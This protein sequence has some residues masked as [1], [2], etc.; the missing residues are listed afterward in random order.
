VTK[1]YS[2]VTGS[3]GRRKIV[4]GTVAVKGVAQ[5][6]MKRCKWNSQTV[7]THIYAPFH[8]ASG[9][10]ANN[11]TAMHCVMLATAHRAWKQLLRNCH[12][13]VV[14]PQSL[15]RFH[16]E[17]PSRLVNIPVQFHRYVAMK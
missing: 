4:V 17:R 2:F 1:Y 5:G 3:V 15:H 6:L 10:D 14:K 16:V 8:V 11:M 12:V 13:P 9:F 7:R